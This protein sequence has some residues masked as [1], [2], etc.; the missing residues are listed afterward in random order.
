MSQYEAKFQVGWMTVNAEGDEP[1]DL[2]REVENAQDLQCLCQQAAMMG[3]K[4]DQ[5][6]IKKL[7]DFLE[8]YYGGELTIEDVRGLD[9]GLSVGRIKCNELIENR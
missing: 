5:K 1:D 7:M 2:I 8:K 9:V 6:E 4:K 3:T